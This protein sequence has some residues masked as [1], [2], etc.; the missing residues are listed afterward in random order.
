MPKI[1]NSKNCSL[2]VRLSNT[3][4]KHKLLRDSTS[5]GVLLVP[6]PINKDLAD[7]PSA[8]LSPKK[9]KEYNNKNNR[10]V[11]RLKVLLA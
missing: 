8:R 6:K 7:V 2:R 9:Q 1:N 10:V 3:N 11:K 4:T 5:L